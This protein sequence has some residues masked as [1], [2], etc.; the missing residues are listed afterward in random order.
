MKRIGA[1]LLSVV[2][3]LS[4]AVPAGAYHWSGN[5]FLDDYYGIMPLFTDIDNGTFSF[6]SAFDS[7]FSLSTGREFQF[8]GQSYSK[9]YPNSPSYY[10]SVSSYSGSLSESIPSSVRYNFSFG[11]AS[12]LFTFDKPVV[13]FSLSGA[14][15]SHLTFKGVYNSSGSRQFLFRLNP[16]FDILVNSNV[17]ASFSSSGVIGL[18]SAV[19]VSSVSFSSDIPFSSFVIRQSSISY[20]YSTT[21]VYSSLE[22]NPYLAVDTSSPLSVSCVYADS[23]TPDPQPFPVSITP[24]VTSLTGGGTVNLTVS[25]PAG[26]TVT[27]SPSVPLSGSGSSW[28]A[29]LPDETATYTFTASFPGSSEY[30]GSSASC[31]V[32]VIKKPSGPVDPDPPDPIVPGEG[33]FSYT[34]VE[35]EKLAE[36]V[37]LS[38]STRTGGANVYWIYDSYETGNPLYP[39]TVPGGSA[40]SMA[41]SR[42]PA[43]SLSSSSGIVTASIPSTSYSF[44]WSGDQRVDSFVNLLTGPPGFSGPGSAAHDY[45]VFQIPLVSQEEIHNIELD[46]FIPVET[47]YRAG[48]SSA[49]RV[50]GSWSLYVN[51]ALAVS[52]T[53][54]ISGNIQFNNF[55]YHSSESITLLE[56]RLVPTAASLAFPSNTGSITFSWSVSLGMKGLSMIY[57]EGEDSVVDLSKLYGQINDAQ[58][59]IHDYETIENQWIDNMSSNWDALK[60]DTFALDTGLVSGF[61]LLTG[62]F[63][64]IW[65]AF[66]IFNVVWV[67]PLLLGIALL[68]IGRISRSGGT[69][70]EGQ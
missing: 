12:F 7:S 5:S 11:G 38:S 55:V 20:S 39:V 34:V 43:I 42:F 24:S 27:A 31:V 48:G 1:I 4:C 70:K 65:T 46:G 62:I 35:G 44:S 16:G 26:T 54:D 63:N 66:G 51:G 23:S 33:D 25:G 69:G 30:L 40:L 8:L 56:L 9:S 21:R 3:L 57:T 36:D 58:D 59:S 22:L 60:L 61:A 28:S 17:I 13:S 14:L 45:L 67:V 29:K 32:Q 50:G 10:Y 41:P 15:V 19:D 53:T 6:L 64:D 2:L 37:V 18:H 47:S 49:S 68:V 52:G